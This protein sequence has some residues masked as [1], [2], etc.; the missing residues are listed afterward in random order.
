MARSGVHR[1]A[2]IRPQLEHKPT[3]HELVN[4]AAA[5]RHASLVGSGQSSR[6]GSLAKFT[7]IRAPLCDK[8]IGVSRFTYFGLK[9]SVGALGRA[10]CCNIFAAA[11]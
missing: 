5:P 7:S 4:C 1:V 9:T 3:W 6:S 10:C 11:E 2:A 8:M